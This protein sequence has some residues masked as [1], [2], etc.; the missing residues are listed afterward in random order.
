MGADVASA[1]NHAYAFTTAFFEELAR[2]G[3]RDV[4]P[5]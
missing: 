3:V 1:P 2:A 5:T 4:S